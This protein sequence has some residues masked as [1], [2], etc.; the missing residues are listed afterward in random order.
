MQLGPLV[1]LISPTEAVDEFNALLE[2]TFNRYKNAYSICSEAAR[3]VITQEQFLDLVNHVKEKVETHIAIER[4][5]A[6]FETETEFSTSP[7]LQLNSGLPNK[8]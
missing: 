4:N 7:G 5:G 6:L 2:Q 3:K 8:A 1:K